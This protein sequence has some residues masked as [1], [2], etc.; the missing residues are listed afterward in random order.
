M[1]RLALVTLTA[2]WAQATSAAELGP[3]WRWPP[4]TLGRSVPAMKSGRVNSAVFPWSSCRGG[5]ADRAAFAVSQ[6][7]DPRKS[8]KGAVRRDFDHS[9]KN[10][11]PMAKCAMNKPANTDCPR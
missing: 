10:R 5:R 8:P 3:Q 7:G 11:G 6:I 1:I 4:Q 9:I 2:S